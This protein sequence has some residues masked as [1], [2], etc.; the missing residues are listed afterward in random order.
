MYCSQ[1]GAQCTSNDRFCSGCGAAVTQRAPQPVYQPPPQMAHVPPQP[2]DYSYPARQ[3]QQAYPPPPAYSPPRAAEQPAYT[4]ASSQSRIFAVLCYVFPI[5]GG[6]LFLLLA[7]G[8]RLVRFHAWQS[9]IASGALLI[10]W[11][12]ARAIVWPLALIAGLAWTVLLIFMAVKTYQGHNISLPVA[13][14]LAEKLAHG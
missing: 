5:I 11:V 8:D 1:C 10:I 6:I 4:E 7:K 2:P 12:I 3:T 14:G 9:I 13:G